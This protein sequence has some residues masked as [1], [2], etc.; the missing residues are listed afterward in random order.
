MRGDSDNT[1]LVD[2]S[3]LD[4]ALKE[5]MIS[6]LDAN[7][8]VLYLNQSLSTKA[9]FLKRDV[10]EAREAGTFS[11]ELKERTVDMFFYEYDRLEE[12]V[13]ILT[14]AEAFDYLDYPN[15]AEF[16]D[17]LIRYGPTFH[18]MV[19]P[20]LLFVCF[21]TLVLIILWLKKIRTGFLLNGWPYMIVS[22][23]VIIT[24][25]VL[26]SS[27]LYSDSVLNLLDTTPA[28]IIKEWNLAPLAPLCG[29][30]I[31][32]TGLMLFAAAIVFLILARIF[33][34]KKR[35]AAK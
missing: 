25:V 35:E 4:A 19:M 29:D 12:G 26:K 9:A 8:A 30:T 27:H 21:L 24:G 18:R 34:V 14:P 33:G 13:L 3:A 16:Y 5:N 32:S 31:V 11:D 6:S 15:A 23:G 7:T 10:L 1:G 2:L 22:V 17:V 20:L 28:D